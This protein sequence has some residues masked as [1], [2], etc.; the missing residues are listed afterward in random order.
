VS[1]DLQ[2][3]TVLRNTQLDA[4]TDLLGAGAR[5]EIRT[6]APPARCS[7]ADTGTLLASI[8]LGRRAFGRAFDGMI[9]KTGLWAAFATATGTAGHFRMVDAS[10]VC[11]LQG[12][13]TAAGQGGLMEFDGDTEIEAEAY[14]ELAEFVLVAGNQ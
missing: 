14:V 13:I 10:G 3:S 8:A 1:A 7:A 9:S 12:T 11:V 2:Y 6:G 4:L 5:L